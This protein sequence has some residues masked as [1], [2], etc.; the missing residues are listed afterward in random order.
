MAG[1]AR[2]QQWREQYPKYTRVRVAHYDFYDIVWTSTPR[3]FFN[4]FRI[5]FML[6]NLVTYLKETRAELDHITWP[7][8]R[9]TLVFTVLVIALSVV[10]GVYLGLLDFGFTWLLNNYII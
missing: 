2:G 4:Y 1:N 8:Q 7:T 3:G 9:Q 6:T 5:T 10:I